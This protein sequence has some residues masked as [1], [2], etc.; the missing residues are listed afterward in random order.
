V[1]ASKLVI[2]GIGAPL[3]I[4]IEET[5]ARLGIE[6]VAGVRNLPGPSFASNKLVIV[7]ADQIPESLKA[8]G[9]VLPLA[10]PA[11]R[12]AALG[13][14]VRLGFSSAETLV[15][16]TAVIARSATIARGVYVGA[17]CT[18]GGAVELGEFA[19]VNTAASVGHHTRIKEFASIGPG[20]T[21]TGNI[22][23]GRGASIGA[24]AVI[25]PE[26][27]IGAHAIVGAGSVVTQSVPAASLVLGNPARVVQTD[28]PALV[29][30]P[31][32]GQRQSVSE[33]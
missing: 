2:F 14:A 22:T 28:L 25:L 23:I 20:T 12:F 30:N 11:N 26:L 1:S 32:L 3:T 27:E 7:E 18:L 6:V 9:I 29:G 8:L 16:P 4:V 17:S 15:D 33:Q 24:G 13:D 19:F 10:T 31:P 21:L 5:C